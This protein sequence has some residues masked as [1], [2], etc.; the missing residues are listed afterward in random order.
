MEAMIVFAMP[1]TREMAAVAKV[2]K[3]EFLH[4]NLVFPTQYVIATFSILYILNISD[5][6]ECSTKAHGCHVNATCKNTDG[7]YSCACKA[8]F[9]GDGRNC[10]DIDECSGDYS[11]HVNAK[12]KNT[13]G[14]YDCVCNAG[15]QGDGS[16]CQDIDE[17]STKAHGC[18]VNATCK[19]T[20]GS[21][22]CACKAGF[23][24]DG[25]NCRGPVT[26]KEMKASLTSTELQ[27]EN[28][29]FSLSLNTTM[30]YSIV[31]SFSRFSC[32][33]GTWHLA[34]KINGTKNTFEYSEPNR[35]ESKEQFNT[36][37]S[38]TGLDEEE[39]KTSAF[40]DTPLNKLCLGMKYEGVTR[41]IRIDVKG[42]SLYDVMKGGERKTTLGKDKWKSLLSGHSPSLNENNCLK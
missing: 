33:E 12:C 35:W 6:D 21:Y 16:S 3:H 18:H 8:G 36:R 13:D 10:R 34:M 14:S 39:T 7:S 27:Q 4:S 32:G 17:C 11:C 23:Y 38:K 30:Q 40:G 19:N 2:S 15:Y 29:L 42:S 37:A 1:V 22:S 24:G 26:C 9:Y 25:R 28:R 41:W 5:I 31:C 20:D